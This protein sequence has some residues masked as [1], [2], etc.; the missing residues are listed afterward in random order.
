[1]VRRD[2]KNGKI[3]NWNVLTIGTTFIQKRIQI[4]PPIGHRKDYSDEGF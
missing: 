2:F 3:H 4:G 1:M